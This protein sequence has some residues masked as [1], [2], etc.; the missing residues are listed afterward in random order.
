MAFN[1]RER[2]DFENLFTFE[3]A[4]NHQGDVAHGKKI[5]K[6]IGGIAKKHKLKAA[7]K[8]QFRDLDTFIHAKHKKKSD[9]KHVPRFLSTR[10]SEAQFKELIAEARKNEL[11]VM[12]TPFD[13]SSV[14]FAEKLDI[15]ILKVASCSAK[16]FPLL[17][18]IAG[19]QK[20]VIASTGGLSIAE[21]DNLVTFLDH[22]YV[23]FAIMHCVAIYPTPA[24]KLQLTQIEIFRK[25]YPG[26]VI[27]FSTHE[28]PDNSE[29]IQMA[30]AKGARIFEK[31]VGVE[32]AAI[33]LNTY[34]ATPE[35]T[36]KWIEAWERARAALGG[37]EKILD[38][39]ER[40]DLL[41]LMRGVF[42]KKPLKKGKPIK[43]GDV[44]FAFPI[45]P[46][47]LSSGKFAEG[48][49][50]DKDYKKDQP[51]SEKVHSETVSPK[52]IVYQT[53]HAV[54]GMLNE[55]KV[56]ITPEF[57]IELSHHYGLEEFYKWGV[58]IIDCINREYCKKILVQLPGQSHP[59]HHHI[60]KE[61]TFHMLA[62]ELHMEV[63]GRKKILYPGDLQII[64]RGMKHRFWTDTGAI[65][66]E[67]SSTH[68][69]DDSYYEDPKIR[70]APRESRKTKLSN[71]GRHQF[72]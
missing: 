23:H 41:T 26:V 20:P 64:Q 17:E 16:D 8:F 3:M 58:V 59:Y 50:A 18:K 56:P 43:A 45:E 10:L 37:E 46:G 11:I 49:V 30:Y 15:D 5:I 4:N 35:Q 21:I 22:R 57:S 65:F 27:G 32:T 13:E 29:N 39:K 62:G 51:I 28:A 67:I 36:E 33:K 53:I 1:T 66:E 24:D 31:H 69:N 12:A 42:A 44:Y 72:D 25:R 7:I 61:E 48:V 55:Y 19:V 68:F 70:N 38:P 71:W 63:D 47:Q 52:H 34:S 40:E 60:K 9:N 14:D 6:A 2:F 54:K